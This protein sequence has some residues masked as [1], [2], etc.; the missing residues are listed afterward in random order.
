MKKLLKILNLKLLLSFYQFILKNYTKAKIEK[1]FKWQ[2]SFTSFMKLY[3][4][5]KSSLK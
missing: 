3:F 2:N 4:Y 1:N 5:F